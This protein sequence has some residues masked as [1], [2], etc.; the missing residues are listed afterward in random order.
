MVY[1]RAE[2]SRTHLEARTLRR[3][4][5]GVGGPNRSARRG[6]AMSGKLIDQFGRTIEYL[7]ISVTDRCNFR[8]SY[9][10]PLEGLPWLPKADIL[11]YEEIRDVAAQL[12]PLAVRRVRITGG[13]PAIRPQLATLVGLR[14]AFPG[15]ED[16]APSPNVVKL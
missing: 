15:V 8:C 4:H 3:R 13:E 11:S 12:A 7:R 2:A 6:A 5:A 1:R 9:C 10:M 16:I 14:R